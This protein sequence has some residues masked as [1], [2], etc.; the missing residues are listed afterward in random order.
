MSN[1]INQDVAKELVAQIAGKTYDD[2]YTKLKFERR[3]VLILDN[4]PTHRSDFTFQ[5]AN[6]LNNIIEFIYITIA[7]V[8]VAASVFFFL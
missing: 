5:V 1:D 6:L 7:T 2:I 3:I 4:V 8:I